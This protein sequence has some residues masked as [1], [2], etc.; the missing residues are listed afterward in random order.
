MIYKHCCYYSSCNCEGDWC[1]NRKVFVIEEPAKE[2][3][4]NTGYLDYCSYLPFGSCLITQLELSHCSMRAL[5]NLMDLQFL[6]S[7]QN[8]FLW[9]CYCFAFRFYRYYSL[10]LFSFA[11]QLLYSLYLRFG[12]ASF[13]LRMKLAEAYWGNQVYEGFYY[14]CFYLNGQKLFPLSEL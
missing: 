11:P 9:Y 7:E 10:Y 12:S 4:Q 13:Y 14:S 5:T 3:C 1:L 2:L 6:G 8:L